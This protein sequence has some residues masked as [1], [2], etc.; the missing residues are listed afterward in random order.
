[1]A[2][3]LVLTP[4]HIH[5]FHFHC[6]VKDRSSPVQVLRWQQ[7]ICHVTFDLTGISTRVGRRQLTLVIHW[8]LKDYLRVF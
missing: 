1:M 6:E 5:N 3:T 4:I 8:V 7:A 2:K